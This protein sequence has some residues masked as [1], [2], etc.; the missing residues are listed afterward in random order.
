[1]SKVWIRNFFSTPICLILTNFTVIGGYSPLRP[2]FRTS[3]MGSP[4]MFI[5]HAYRTPSISAMNIKNAIRG[6]SYGKI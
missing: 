4:Q 5:V 2:P 6:R 1:M 3:M